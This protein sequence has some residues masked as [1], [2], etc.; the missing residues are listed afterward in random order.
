MDTDTPV[1]NDTP[2]NNETPVSNETPV[3]T[4]SENTTSITIENTESDYP[5][6]DS[7]LCEECGKE[8]D[9]DEARMLYRGGAVCET[10]AEIHNYVSCQECEYYF[11]STCSSVFCKHCP[12]FIPDKPP[13]ISDKPSI[14]ASDITPIAD[15]QNLE[16]A[17]GDQSQDEGE[18]CE[19]CQAQLYGQLA[20]EFEEIE[21]M[22][23]IS[24]RETST[25]NWILCD[26]CNRLL[27][28][29]C[30]QHPDTGFCDEC[31][32]KYG[33]SPLSGKEQ[34]ERS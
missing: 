24:F 28:R 23:V 1:S 29:S 13:T 2:I 30:C 17:R 12:S 34:E 31:L 18:R 21:G 15:K 25:R 7:F 9:T 10:C 6:G 32:Q 33:V 20:V 14:Q 3:H 22:S 19:K 27:C 8:K 11:R 4:E 16:Q 26:A 5:S